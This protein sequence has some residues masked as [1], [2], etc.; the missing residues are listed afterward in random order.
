MKREFVGKIGVDSGSVMIV[1]PCYFHD[2]THWDPQQIIQIATEEAKNGDCKTAINSMRLAKEKTELQNII[3]NWDNVC[4]D[5]E[6]AN[7][8]PR[9]YAGGVISPTRNGDGEYCVYVTR[10]R[11][12]KIKKMEIEF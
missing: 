12:G 4:I 11:D 6:K 9:E 10:D 2:P 8:E 1:D 3:G 7:F 5:A